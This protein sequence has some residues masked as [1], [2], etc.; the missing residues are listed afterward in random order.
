MT[1]YARLMGELSRLRAHVEAQ[2][3]EAD[4]WLEQQRAAAERAVERA[5]HAVRRA[6]EELAA[7]RRE[8]EAVDA[9][10][11]RLWREAVRRLGPSQDEP[12]VPIPGARV[13]PEVLLDS[14]RD[15]LARAR[16][17]RAL[18]GSAY[19][20]LGAVGVLGAAAAYVVSL[21]ARLGGDR[22]GGD[23]ATGM[24]VLGLVVALLGPAVGLVPAKALAE[25]RHAVLDAKAVVV[26]VLSGLVTTVAL[27]ALW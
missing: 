21:A 11:G 27:L 16:Q 2:I 17:P 18:P 1:E 4:S 26:V 20:L 6:E 9:T 7:A 24:P 22:Y 13:H 10:V 25:R 15:L 14:V 8:V 19:P 3:A 23:L 5:E 12:P